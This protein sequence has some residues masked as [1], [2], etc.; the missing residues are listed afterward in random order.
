MNIQKGKQILNITGKINLLQIMCVCL[1]T[2]L[3]LTL[4]DPLDCSP[5]GSSVHGDS[6][7]KNTGVGCH[8]LLQGIFLTQELNTG[9]LHWRQILYPS[10]PPGKPTQWICWLNIWGEK[11]LLLGRSF[12]DVIK[13]WNT[14]LPNNIY[15]YTSIEKSTIKGTWSMIGNILREVLGSSPSGSREFE[16][17]TDRR[18]KN[19]CI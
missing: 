10:E 14:P 9:L 4:C 12:I 1:V 2:Q 5:A 3:R 19:L 16:G 8:S 11:K 6:P 13:Y 15:F 7:G 17:E 18:G